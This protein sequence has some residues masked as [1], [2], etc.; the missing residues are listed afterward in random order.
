MPELSLTAPPPRDELLPRLRQRLPEAVPG[1]RVVAEGV[2]GAEATIDFVG[3]DPDGRVTLVLVG[4]EGQDLELLARALAQRAWVTPRLRDWQQLAPELG[5]RSEAGV[6]VVL[7]CPEFRPACEAAARSLG[8]E[9]PVLVRYRCVRNGAGI[10][11]L[12]EPRGARALTAGAATGRR[13]EELPA[14]RTGLTDADLGLS[15]EERR[16]FAP[17]GGSRDESRPG[18]DNF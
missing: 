18:E 1:L 7:L 15:P 17:R 9:A 12:V 10:E 2:L 11:A 5:V 6:R 13:A 16:E 8:A 4:G 14:F 3:L